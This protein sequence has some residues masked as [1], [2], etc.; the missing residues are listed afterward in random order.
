MYT[1]PIVI[2]GLAI[3]GVVLLLFILVMLSSVN[4]LKLK[5]QE[6]EAAFT[7]YQTTINSQKLIEKKLAT[8]IG[9]MEY[10]DE[11]LKRGFVQVMNDRVTA[12]MEGFKP[13]QLRLVEIGRGGRGS[14]SKD[15]EAQSA[16]IMLTFE[17]G[18]GPMQALMGEL[19]TLIPQLELDSMDIG[20]GRPTGIRKEK[21]L[22]FKIVYSAWS[23]E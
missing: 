20:A 12:I 7:A 18:F 9:E 16:A 14:L 10:W 13:N 4:N 5:R 21:E 22:T 6:K 8:R 3:P 2:F 11:N 1:K 17:G 19:E 15:G 23:K